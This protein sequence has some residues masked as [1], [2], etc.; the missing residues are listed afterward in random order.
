M[1][2]ISPNSNDGNCSVTSIT[3]WV[4]TKNI[5]SD[6]FNSTNRFLWN[7]IDGTRRSAR[8]GGYR[9]TIARSFF[10]FDT[11]GISIAPSSAVFFLKGYNAAAVNADFFA[12]K[13]THST[14]LSAGDF[15]AF[16]LSSSP[17]ANDG[18]GGGDMESLVT[19][20]SSEITTFNAGSFNAITLNST[21]LADMASLATFKFCLME[22]VHDM[23]DIEP[24]AQNANS[25]YYMDATSS[26]DRPYITYIEGTSA[27]SDSATFFGTNF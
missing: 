5:T 3:S 23:R 10:Y 20:Y 2:T 24:S 7:A 11:S 26:G 4:A 27:P 18:S 14:T 21:A 6:S 1:P 17:G 16:P 25:C 8:A 9:W 12:I 22:S 19:K 13:S 15:D